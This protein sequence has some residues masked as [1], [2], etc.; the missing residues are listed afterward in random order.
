[1]GEELL[2]RLGAAQYPTSVPDRGAVWEAVHWR[3]KVH[4]G[5][6]VASRH[7]APCWPSRKVP[8]AMTCCM[9]VL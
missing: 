7:S 5:W 1:M 4:M 9:L 3:G 8:F 6:D 2:V